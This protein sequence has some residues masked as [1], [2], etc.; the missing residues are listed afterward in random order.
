MTPLRKR[1]IEAMR[2]RGLAPAT[3]RAYLMAVKK[4]VR[5][6]GRPPDQISE[7]E[8]RRFFLYLIEEEQLARSTTTVILCGLKFFYEYTLEEEWP[9][10]DLVRPLKKKKVPVVLSRQE[11]SRILRCLRRPHYRVCLSLIYSCGLRIS[12][13][14]HVQVNHIDSDRMQLLVKHGKRNKNRYV[15]LPEE[16]LRQLRR[17][18]RRH[19]DPVWLFPK[20]AHGVAI[21][22]ADRPINVS[23][24]RAAF[25]AA[26][27]ESGVRKEA[28]VHTLRHSWAT[29]LLESGVHLRLIQRWLGH[30]SLR[31][32]AVY[33]H[34]TGNAEVAALSN[35]NALV[36]EVA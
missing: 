28:T 35:L 5:Y 18:W 11:V 10:L 4:L 27:A 31:S 24:V 2:L 33:L 20:R 1:F 29:H 21:P 22:N 3:Q 36:A 12:E 7:E 17:Y 8:I 9:I 13:G 14:V 34:L 30:S 23:G 19:R 32:T 6:A 25:V 15:P 16:M 26:L